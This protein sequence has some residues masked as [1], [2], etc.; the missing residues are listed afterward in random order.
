MFYS[1]THKNG[2]SGRQRFNASINTIYSTATSELFTAPVEAQDANE[3]LLELLVDERVA[4]RIDRTVEV[5]Q[6][7]GDVV[8]QSRYARLAAFHARAAEP[9]Q[10]RQDVPGRPAEH[11]RS[12]NDGD[13]PQSL[14]C[15]VLVLLLLFATSTLAL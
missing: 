2:N 7:V 1:C 5:A 15:S 10:Q 9:D 6:P 14:A 4:E 3:S 12:Q 13:R 8:E 11:E